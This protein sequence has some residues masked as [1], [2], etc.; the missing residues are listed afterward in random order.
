MKFRLVDRITE[1][2]PQE[3][4]CGM[5]VLSFE[6]YQLKSAFGGSPHLPES[7]IVESMFQLGNWL[8]ML[9]SDFSHIGL[10]IRFV[11]FECSGIACPGTCLK[12]EITVRSYRHDRIVFD[13][14]VLADNSVITTGF[15]CLAMPVALGDYA[16]PDDMK[17]LFSE[18]YKPN[19][20][21]EIH[22]EP[23]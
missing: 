18:I 15:G 2:K 22:H 20:L 12:M 21:L 1:Y 16:N 19:R 10:I 8:I 9:S 14:R 3:R 4:I 13:G 5:K 17:M 11:K 6:E 23:T 7:L